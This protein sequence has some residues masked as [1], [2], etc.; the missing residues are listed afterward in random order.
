MKVC[1]QGLGHIT[2]M[3]HAHISRSERFCYPSTF[4]N[5]SS[6]ATGLI[7]AMFHMEPFMGQGT[8][9]FPD[10]LGYMTKMAGMLIYG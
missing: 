3:T 6:K 10:C 9:V 1:S 5:I 8:E 7:E 2:K 4:P